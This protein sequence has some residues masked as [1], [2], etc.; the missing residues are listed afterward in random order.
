[1]H[2]FM[3]NQKIIGFDPASVRNLGWSKLTISLT[4]E[5]RIATTAGT[6]VIEK[7][8][9]PWQAMWPIFQV[10]DLFLEKEKP[11]IVVIEKTSSF[12][13]GFVAGQVSGCMG[14]IHACCGKHNIDLEFVHPTHMK[15]VLTGNGRAT[16][17]QVKKCVKETIGDL[18]FDSE[19][20]YD[21]IGIVLSYLKDEQVKNK[22]QA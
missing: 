16:K 2:R 11:D 4:T 7:V 3:S 14:V 15:K 22:E 1:M 20:A 18:K 10:V 19:H 17:S 8:E 6:F 12:A 9:Q 13:G 5:E 21:A